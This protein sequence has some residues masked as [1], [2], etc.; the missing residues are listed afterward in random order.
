MAIKIAHAASD[1]NKKYKGGKAGDQTGKEICIRTWYNRPWNVIIRFK[2][3][4]KREKIA[5][6]MERL[7]ANDNIGYDQ[8]QRNTALAQARKVGYDP[9]KIKVPCETDCSAAVVI[10]CCYSGI[11]EN[12]LYSSGNSAYTGNLKKKL[13]A[14]GEVEIFTASKYVASDKYLFRGDI[15]LY[16]GHHVAVALENGSMVKEVLVVPTRTL[17]DG[18]EGND[19]KWLQTGLNKIMKSGLVIDGE[20]GRATIA[21]VKSFQKKYGL[22]V[23]GIFGVNSRKTMVKLLAGETVVVVPALAKPTL[24]LG[25]DGVQVRY[26]QQD[27]NYVMKANLEVDGEFG[28]ATL[29]AM[30]KFQRKYGLDDDGVY[31][32]KSEA[33]MKKKLK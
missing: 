33:M 26:L 32:V 12:K 2:D 30:K 21:A 5:E 20:F 23:D 6:G 10:C 1:E 13:V 3:A 31:G 29:R 15:L 19:V 8:N 28:K 7:A 22:E 9:A 24:R 11:P 14:T 27:L 17:K 18:C 4:E 16:E 25:D